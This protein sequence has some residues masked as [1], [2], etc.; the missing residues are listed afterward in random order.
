M[1][2]QKEIDGFSTLLKSPDF[3]AI[4]SAFNYVNREFNNT[5]IITL[6]EVRQNKWHR[7]DMNFIHDETQD[8]NEIAKRA[9][10]LKF[11]LMHRAEVHF[12]DFF[13]RNTTIWFKEANHAMLCK[14]EFG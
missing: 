7:F 6:E 12:V 1:I 11:I 3:V 5:D 9:G 14:L 2:T 10:I 4:I 13:S 8:G